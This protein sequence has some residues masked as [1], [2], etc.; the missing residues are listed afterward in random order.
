M[1]K[2][3]IKDTKEKA[4]EAINKIGEDRIK[5]YLFRVED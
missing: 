4:Q 1:K 5:K 2:E 3:E